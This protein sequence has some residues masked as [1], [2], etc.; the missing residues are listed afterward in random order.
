MTEDERVGWHHRFTGRDLGTS[1]GDG[2]GQR[3]L[4]CCSPWGQG[5]VAHD[6]ALNIRNSFG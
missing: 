4:V 6:L 2:E 3:T 1:L 5:S